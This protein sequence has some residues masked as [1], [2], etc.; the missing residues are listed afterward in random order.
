MRNENFDAILK[1]TRIGTHLWKN[2]CESVALEDEMEIQSLD[3]ALESLASAKKF[4]EFFGKVEER[5]ERRMRAALLSNA[6][7][8][9][10]LG[11]RRIW[12]S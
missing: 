12:P 2:F 8:K 5:K 3:S 6:K 1:L 10:E 4:L 9:M 11:L 7:G